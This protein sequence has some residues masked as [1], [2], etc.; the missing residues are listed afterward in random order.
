M[1]EALEPKQKTNPEGDPTT[2]VSAPK[3][4]TKKVQDE[5][6]ALKGK[7]MLDSDRSTSDA[8]KRGDAQ[9]EKTPEQKE[10]EAA[11]A[12]VQDMPHYARMRSLLG[13]EA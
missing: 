10:M 11:Q 3:A 5:M 1:S 7:R 9:G 8:G 13:K 4:E 2:S 12:E 6:A